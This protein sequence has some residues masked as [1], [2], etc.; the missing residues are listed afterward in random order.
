MVGWAMNK[1]CETLR[2]VILGHKVE[3][4]PTYSCLEECFKQLSETNRDLILQAYALQN[5]SKVAMRTELAQRL[6][7]SS[8]ELRVRVYMIRRDLRACVKACLEKEND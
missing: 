8:N 5:R 1:I 7:I 2:A 6:G 3:S 4:D